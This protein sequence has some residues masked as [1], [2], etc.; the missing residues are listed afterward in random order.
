MSSIKLLLILLCLASNAAA[1]TYPARP[2]RMVVPFPPSGGSDVIARIFAPAYSAALGQQ[3]IIDNRAGANGNVGTELV[4]RAPPD[5]YTLLFNGSGT[6]AINPSL[7][8]KL[9]YD[10]LRDFAPITLA[11]LQPHVLVIHPSLPAKSVQEL[12]AIARAQPGRMNFA[13]SGNGSLAH[14]AGE[15]FRAQARIDLVHVPY[16]GAAPALVDVI[17]GQVHLVFASS[18]S[19]M[20]HVKV[21]RLRAL[22]VTTPRRV[23]ALPDLPTLTEAGLPGF[24]VMGWYGLLAPAATPAPIVAKLNAD[25][26]ATLKQAD[27]R[28]KLAGVGLEVETSTPQG[29]ADFMK[30]EI[31]KYAKVVKAANIKV[32]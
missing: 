16:K 20:S 23:S 9:P 27:V 30:A 21:N 18:P 14:L 2:V 5:G 8:E 3:I 12:I 25:M 13:S 28:Q 1:Q 32:D 11:V 15:M 10:A 26:V 22:G 24:E 6:L 4:A 17:A 31:A 19:V 29:F 7:Y